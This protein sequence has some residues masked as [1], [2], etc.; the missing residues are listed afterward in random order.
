MHLPLLCSCEQQVLPVSTGLGR[1]YAGFRQGFVSESQT[2]PEKSC[3]KKRIS[4]RLSK[5]RVDIVSYGKL[6][7]RSDE[8]QVIS[9]LAACS[10]YVTMDTNG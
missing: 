6:R 9:A 10:N 1:K 7:F 2:A 3:A 8:I 5:K 4:L